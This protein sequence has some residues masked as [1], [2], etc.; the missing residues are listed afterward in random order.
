MLTFLEVG[1]GGNLVQ[2]FRVYAWRAVP[3]FPQIALCFP[4]LA[5]RPQPFILKS[6]KWTERKNSL[7]SRVLSTCSI[8]IN[9]RCKSGHNAGPH[10][11]KLEDLYFAK[12]SLIKET[13]DTEVEFV[14][15][16][17]AGGSVK[18]VASGVNF[19]IFTHF[20]CF[21]FT[22]T[23]EIGWN[24]RCKIFNLKIR[25][26]KILDKFHVCA[27]TLSTVR[28]LYLVMTLPNH[29]GRGIE[30][31][32]ELKLAVKLNFTVHLM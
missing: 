28:G 5:L 16:V 11:K 8:S 20:L 32:A 3:S 2:G 18:F 19:S 17:S 31:G 1:F 15:P 25:R 29:D 12:I 27:D 9:I 21:F 23:V 6:Q 14:H 24:W 22:K 4:S 7:S 30:G 13:A 10:Q 26:C